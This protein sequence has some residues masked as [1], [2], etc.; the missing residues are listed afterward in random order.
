MFVFLIVIIY[1][2][3]GIYVIDHRSNSNY[4]MEDSCITITKQG[5]NTLYVEEYCTTAYTDY[6]NVNFKKWTRI[7]CNK[8]KCV[9]NR[10]NFKKKDWETL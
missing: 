1:I 7:T 8:D 10:Y 9:T 5:F 4:F 3:I 6:K 2:I